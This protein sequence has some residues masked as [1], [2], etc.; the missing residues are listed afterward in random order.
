MPRIPYMEVDSIDDP[1]VLGY[2]ETAMRRGTPRAESQLVRAHVPAAIRS[3]S[4]TM[5]S[6]FHNGVVDHALKELCRVYIAKSLACDYCSTQRSPSSREDGLAEGDY[7]DLLRFRES[8]RYDA[9]QRAALEYTDAVLWDPR[10]ADDQL[11]EE[12]YRH[13]STPELVELGY[14]IATAA[15]QGRWIVTLDLEH[16]ERFD[17]VEGTGAA[18]SRSRDAVAVK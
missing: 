3:F 10:R 6:V 7:D 13:F 5:E 2:I 12:L 15:G 16:L 9:R 11:W 18:G 17:P 4:Q 1:E 8:P 14:F